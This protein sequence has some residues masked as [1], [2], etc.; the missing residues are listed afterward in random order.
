MVFCGKSL[1]GLRT[2][3]KRASELVFVKL[4]IGICGPSMASVLGVSGRVKY[5]KSKE[6]NWRHRP[7]SN[8][9]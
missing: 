8:R 6:N 7:D 1:K 2:Q 4:V 3:Y 5:L 9:G